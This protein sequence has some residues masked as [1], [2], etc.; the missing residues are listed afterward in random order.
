MSSFVSSI[1]QNI[2]ISKKEDLFRPTHCD[3]AKLVGKIALGILFFPYGIFQ[4]LALIATKKY[5]SQI[6]GTSSQALPASA[7]KFQIKTA[8]GATLSAGAFGRS[9]KPM[10]AQK[11]II[12]VPGMGGC[13]QAMAKNLAKISREKNCI[14]IGMN[15][16]HK[17]RSIRDL[18][19]DVAAAVELL[20]KN[21]AKPENIVL[22]G[23][24]LGAAI[25][26]KVAAAYNKHNKPLRLIADRGPATSKKFISHHVK[27]GC[28]KCL[29]HIL[30]LSS[31]WDLNVTKDFNSIP[32]ANKAIIY[33][34]K[35]R[36]VHYHNSIYYNAKRASGIKAP[37][38]IK[39]P[40][41]GHAT[42]PQDS[43]MN[44]LLD[45]MLY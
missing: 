23:F 42:Q 8:D 25:G 45:K 36:M 2:S 12:A 18:T 38:F 20:L 29:A 39:L 24:S 30:R 32:N 28:L 40:N 3:R 37:N 34:K 15:F 11:F 43:K 19:R 17:P 27:N 44:N 41:G 10:N 26:T 5:S 6:T 4:I 22:Y 33:A 35:D 9:V 14:A 13:W 31:N 1:N 7:Q 21:G 16:R